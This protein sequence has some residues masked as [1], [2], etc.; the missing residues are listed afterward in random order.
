MVE[1]QYRNFDDAAIGEELI[2]LVT[3]LRERKREKIKIDF[4]QRIAA[5]QAAGNRAE[6]QKLLRELQAT[7]R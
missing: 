4:A 5:A 3:R 1:E 7:I 2:Q 6:L